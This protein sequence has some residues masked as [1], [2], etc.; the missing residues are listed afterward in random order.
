MSE[1]DPDLVPRN[2]EPKDW[3]LEQEYIQEITL[4][5]HLGIVLPWEQPPGPV[6]G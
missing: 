5:C 3:D 1:L 4:E 6:V 2:Q